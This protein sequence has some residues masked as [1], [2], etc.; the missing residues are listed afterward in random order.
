MPEILLVKERVLPVTGF[1]NQIHCPWILL[2]QTDWSVHSRTLAK[3]LRYGVNIVVLC[4]CFVFA[5]K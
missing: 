3:L 1:D 2:M 5:F 4:N